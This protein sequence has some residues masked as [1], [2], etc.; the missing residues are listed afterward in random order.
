MSQVLKVTDIMRKKVLSVDS[1]SDGYEVGKLILEDEGGY[2]LVENNDTVI[3][4][5]TCRHFVEEILKWKAAP[6]DMRVRHIMSSP[7]HMI[8]SEATVEKAAALMSSKK[9]RRLPVLKEEKI[10]GIVLAGDI[11]KVVASKNP[12][13]L[14]EKGKVSEDLDLI[15]LF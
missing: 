7:V 11:A 14:V 8:D 10:I 1:A 3:G 5:V 6:P 13:E 2:V 15:P 4:I 12:E 9:I